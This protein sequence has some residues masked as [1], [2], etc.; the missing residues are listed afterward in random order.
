MSTYLMIF[1]RNNMEDSRRSHPSL[2][3]RSMCLHQDG[4]AYQ[5][6]ALSSSQILREILGFVYEEDTS[7]SELNLLTLRYG[8]LQGNASTDSKITGTSNKQNH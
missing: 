3:V 6:P 4:T 2:C 7:N 8:H 1:P 5:V